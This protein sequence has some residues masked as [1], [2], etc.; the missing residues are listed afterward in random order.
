MIVTTGLSQEQATARILELAGD[1]A[2]SSDKPYLVLTV[3]LPGSGKST[4]CRRL[5]AATGAVVLESDALRAALFTRPAHDVEESR[6]LFKA[7]YAAA[8]SLL[9]RG[10]DVIVDAT[11]LRERDRVNAYRLAIDLGARLLVLHFRAPYR[12]IA[13]RMALRTAGADPEDRSTADLSVYQRMAETEEPISAEHW[14]VDTSDQDAT[15]AAL[16]KAIATLRPL[17][18]GPEHTGGTST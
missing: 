2:T 13:E 14:T 16:K 10:A 7:I 8:E 15:E 5:A 11:N 1:P 6:Q 12:V 18:A 4:F 9:R 3:G 17:P